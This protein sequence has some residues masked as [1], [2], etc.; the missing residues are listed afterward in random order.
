MSSSH[1]PCPFVPCCV[2]ALPARPVLPYLLHP[3]LHCRHLLYLLLFRPR[4]RHHPHPPRHR[5]HHFLYLRE[6]PFALWEAEVVLAGCMGVWRCCTTVCGALSGA[7]GLGAF[8]AFAPEL[9]LC[10]AASSAGFSTSAKLSCLLLQKER[11][12][13]GDPLPRPDGNSLTCSCTCSDD[14][15]GNND[16]LVA[17]RQLGYSGGSSVGSADQFN[18][19]YPITPGS[20]SILL[21]DLRC[22]PSVHTRIEDCP[23]R[24]WG[25]HNCVHSED[26]GVYCGKLPGYVSNA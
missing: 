23:S 2:Q 22:D 5:L 25:S 14:D 11:K 12:S 15:F 10:A 17:C 24:G 1:P 13:Y 7:C 9:G 21:D 20:G 18:S 3:R 4:H 8:V 19:T 16:A 26:V 6:L